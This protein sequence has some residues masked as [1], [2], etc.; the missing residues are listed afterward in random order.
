M[1]LCHKAGNSGRY[2]EIEVSLSAEPA[3]RAHGDA[4]IGEAVPDL[5]GKG[6]SHGLWCLTDWID[7]DGRP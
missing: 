5:A 6:V 1:K 7:G 3:H 2:V 4:K